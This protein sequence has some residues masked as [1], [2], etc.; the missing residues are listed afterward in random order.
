MWWKILFAN[1]L[2]WYTVYGISLLGLIFYRKQRI[3]LLLM[4]GFTMIIGTITTLL[5]YFLADQF[6]GSI[7]LKMAC[8]GIMIALLSG[9]WTNFRRRNGN[10]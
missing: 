6:Y 9:L 10:D 7:I 8:I 3:V 5:L 1:N 2:I 4:G